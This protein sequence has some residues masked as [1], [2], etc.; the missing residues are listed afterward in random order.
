VAHLLYD[1]TWKE[2]CAWYLEIAKVRIQKGSAEDGA[3]ARQTLLWVYRRILAL[4]HPLMPFITEEIWDHLPGKRQ[5]LILG[6]WPTPDE[7]TA[8]G[9]AEQEIAFFQEAVITVRNLRSEMNVSPAKQVPLGV[10]AEGAEAEILRR[11]ELPLRGLARVAELEISPTYTKPRHSAAGVAGSAELFVQLEGV[12]DLEAERARL[13]R[14]LQKVAAAQKSS[15]RKLAN[16]DFLNRAKPEV[17]AR[18]R[19]KLAQLQETRGKIE[20]ALAAL[21]D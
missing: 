20:Q 13:A 18:E 7:A 10:R 2:F 9:A 1:F 8:D 14:E 5:D 19:E 3:R 12:I 4:L 21:E 11:M 6:P 15:Q 17:V 16:E